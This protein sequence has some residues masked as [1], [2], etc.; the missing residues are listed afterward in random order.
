[1]RVPRKPFRAHRPLRNTHGFKLLQEE[2]PGVTRRHHI[3]EEQ[4]HH[5]PPHY[6][7]A[8]QP[9]FPVASA[10]IQVGLSQ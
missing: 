9:V 6:M 8:P 4:P 5:L 7:L 1:M 2:L 10:K 3:G